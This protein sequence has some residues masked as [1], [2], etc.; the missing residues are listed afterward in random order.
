MHPSTLLHFLSQPEKWEDQV[1]NERTMGAG[2][3]GQTAKLEGNNRI[4]LFNFAARIASCCEPTDQH[5]RQHHGGRP[6]VR[7]SLMD[8]MDGMGLP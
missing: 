3:N 5:L 7:L 4:A 2:R 6:A 1:K 8:R